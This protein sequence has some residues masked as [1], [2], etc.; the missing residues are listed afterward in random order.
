MSNLIEGEIFQ[1]ISEITNNCPCLFFF[2]LVEFISP[3]QF[4]RHVPERHLLPTPLSDR[5]SLQN[6]AHFRAVVL[7]VLRVVVQW[8]C[9]LRCTGFQIVSLNFHQLALASAADVL[10]RIYRP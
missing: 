5:S 3:C 9:F 7:H 10:R 8:L 6:L 2:I 1:Q 4:L